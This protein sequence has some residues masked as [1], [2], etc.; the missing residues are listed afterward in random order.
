MK[1]INYF[2]KRA[3]N[4]P[5]MIQQKTK[6]IVIVNIIAMALILLNIIILSIIN[7]EFV[8]SKYYVHYMLISVGIISLIVVKNFE[9]QFAG[10]FFAI[11][12]LALEIIA[13]AFFKE[14]NGSFMP[15]I[16]SYFIIT[17]FYIAGSIF[18]SKTVLFL[19]G[20]MAILGI[21]GIY[22][23]HQDIVSAGIKPI[24][25]NSIFSILGS[26]MALYF[27]YHLSYSSQKITELHSEK[28]DKQNKKLQEIIQELKESVKV[29]RDLSLKL[30]NT[31][32]NL[33]NNAGGQAANIEEMTSTIEN[34]TLSIN[35]NAEYAG[36]TSKITENS[37]KL[38]KKSDLA[39]SRVFNSISD[40]SSQ[41]GI[42]N[43][44]AR[45]TNLLALN[46]AIEAA[47][48]GNAGK[49]F[50]V[51]AAEVK[52]L[53]EK[54]QEAAKQIVSLVNEGISLSDQAGTYMS[55]M[56][57]EVDK[58][59]NY[60]LQISESVSQEKEGINQINSGMQVINTM[61]QEISR[62]SENI[63]SLSS[64][65]NENSEKL[66]KLADK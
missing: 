33:S 14:S 63:N 20:F 53:A 38:I 37:K 10:N 1:L 58:S 6:A 64:I 46:A 23:L 60:I 2:T 40:I 5:Y 13:V 62:I 22:F 51:V 4:A 3:K 45:Q 17:V 21:L 50:S 56:V 49:G 16:A 47:R 9:Y 19:N 34:L 7:K 44:I 29:Q 61:A 36:N 59:F 18:A 30:Q 28:V 35:N 8:F 42:I 24:V 26:T 25:I 55:Q 48:A 65:L 32:V 15:Y 57:N 12:I 66:K 43:E 27:I 31:I 54:S 11:A 52:K 39:L 41:I